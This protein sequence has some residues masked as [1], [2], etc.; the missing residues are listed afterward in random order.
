MIK[1]VQ[2][3]FIKKCNIP[4][5]VRYDKNTQLEMFVSVGKMSRIKGSVIGK[6]SYLGGNCNLAYCKIGSFTSIGN[7]VNVINGFHPSSIFVSTHPVFYSTRKKIYFS[8][9][10]LFDE[11]KYTNNHYY[12]EIGN[13][14]WIGADVKILAGVSIGDGA[15]I[16]TGA[17]VTR[18]VEP[19]GIY[20]GV[21]A[22][23]IRYRF[24]EET[25]SILLR[26]KWW[27][28][29]DNWLKEHANLFVNIDEYLKECK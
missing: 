27:N 6:Y 19:F 5:S 28:K 13:D 26:N 12:V 29:D 2:W 9:K 3:K 11:Y 21:P 20:A 23:L 7:N 14:V 4:I 10:P 17:V 25:I 15:I 22:K 1:L 8:E 16:A 24:S 18:D